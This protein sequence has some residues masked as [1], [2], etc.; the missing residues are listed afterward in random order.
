MKVR[1]SIFLFLNFFMYSGTY[2]TT[3]PA[4]PADNIAGLVFGD[5]NPKTGLSFARDA[6]GDTWVRGHIV[7]DLINH[8][9]VLHVP[10]V[11]VSDYELYVYS[12]ETLIHANKN[13]DNNQ[14]RIRSRYP[15]CHFTASEPTYYLNIGQQ[16]RSKLAISIV[17]R[18]QFI[19]QEM[20]S[21]MRN[22]LYYG[23]VIMSIVF[24]ILFYFIFWDRRFVIY[25]ALQA[26]LL[27]IF[28]YEDGIFYYFSRGTWELRYF[29]VWS[30]SICATLA[31][32]FT[33]YF[34]EL[35]DRIPRFRSIAISIMVALFSSV[36][37][38]TWTDSSFFRI[39][40]SV[41]CYL[42]PGICLY[43][44]IRMFR[45][46]VYARFLLLTFGAIV[47]VGLAHTLNNFIDTSFFSFFSMDTIRLA[48]AL[49]IIAIS[50]V[51][52]FK[53]R[54]L[55]EENE[56]YRTELY[57][58]L[59]LPSPDHEPE[60]P[61]YTMH[62]D[63][64]IKNLLWT[65]ADRYLLTEREVEVLE[66][67]WNGDS[68]SEIAEKLYISINTVKFHVTGLYSKL[69]VTNRSQARLLKESP[70]VDLSDP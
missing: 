44:A 41:F 1:L 3:M 19:Q 37:V 31:G 12:G 15:L 4:L 69:K 54:A 50:F 34:L 8:P 61:P 7:S 21:L 10:S 46:N 68:N 29:L 55:R 47:L 24:N 58:Y 52:I 67:I 66:C 63:A 70:V 36:L 20:T 11:H 18:D 45:E 13:E 60:I 23:L 57:D 59:R 38:Y 32:L 17:A 28:F 48:S 26:S 65:I 39:L 53:V 22:N 33:Y 14:Q 5:T 64:D 35:K 56:R 16:P 30:I 25:A 9:A 43:H 2:A 40:I 62:D 6:R 27:S 42:L 51:L 49:E